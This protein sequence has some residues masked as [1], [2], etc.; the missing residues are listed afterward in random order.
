MG[1]WIRGECR[2]I[3]N[4]DPNSEFWMMVVPLTN[5]E[6]QLVYLP[7]YDTAQAIDYEDGSPFVDIRP[8]PPIPA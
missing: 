6:L 1:V 5:E 3:T 2:V 4:R 8:A 7:E